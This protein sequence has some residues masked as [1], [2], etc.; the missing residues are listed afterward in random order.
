MM[1]TG[2]IDLGTLPSRLNSFGIGLTIADVS[3]GA[4]PL[5]YFN[6]AFRDLTGYGEEVLGTNCRFLQ[7]SLE[8]EE[9]RAEIRLAIAERRRTQV[10]L[11]N[12]RADGEMF[13]NLLLLLPVG[14][15]PGLPEMMLGTQIDIGRRL[16]GEERGGPANSLD[17]SGFAARDRSLQLQVERRR[18]TAEAA[19][20]VTQS[21]CA[22]HG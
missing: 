8:N 15:Y 17:N 7:G 6:P 13:H 12:E 5:I 3:D 19:L 10:V 4:Q 18:I 22:L 9:A 2:P 16:S 21:W 20:R 1:T 11:K 14:N